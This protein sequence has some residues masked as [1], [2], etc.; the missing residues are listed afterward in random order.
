MNK[1][2]PIPFYPSRSSRRTMAQAAVVVGTALLFAG[3][4]ST[5]ESHVVSAPPPAAPGAVVMAAQQPQAVP[6]QPAQVV[7][8]QAPPAMQQEVV[9][10]RPSSDHVWIAGYWTWRNNRYEW[11]AGRWE[12]PPRSAAVW[13]APRWERLNDGTYRFYEG[14]WN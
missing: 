1:N 12:L 11:V 6:S 13:V 9:Q 3:C 4:G 10:A 8:V 2:Q 14:Y 7:V 5:P